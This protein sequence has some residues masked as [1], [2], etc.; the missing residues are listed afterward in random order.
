MK[1]SLFFGKIFGIKLYVHWTFSLLIAYVIWSAWSAGLGLILWSIALLISVSICI[2]LHEFGHALTAKRYRVTTKHIILLPIGGVAQL[3]SLPKTPKQE[4]I[5]ALAGPLVSLLIAV[6][7]APFID[8]HKLLSISSLLSFSPTNFL[9]FLATVNFWLAIFNLIPAFPMDG[10]RVLRAFL[11]MHIDYD[12]ATNVASGIGKFIGLTMVISGFYL[13]PTLMFIGVFLIIV[14][15]YE[16]AATRT[17]HFLSKHKVGDIVLKDIP[18]LESDLLV[19][20]AADQLLRTQNRNFVVTAKG[21][22]VGSISREDIVKAIAH[23]Q[24]ESQVG[25][26]MNSNLKYFTESMPLDEAWKI[27]SNDRSK[28]AMVG[29]KV[30]P[31]GILEEGNIEELI[32]VKAV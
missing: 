29:T 1:S 9:F 22:P 17:F 13:N 24:G 6:V 28:V 4:M 18:V 23:D 16:A 2:V 14:G 15:K 11:A 8:I 26:V 20:A 3:E 32:L 31:V 27:L 19:K 5:I 21:E 25:A 30:N 12:K 10:G 7:I